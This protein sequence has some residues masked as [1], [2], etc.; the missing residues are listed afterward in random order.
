M[1]K[2]QVAGILDEIGTLLE[3]QGENP[4]RCLAYRN[5]ARAL[6]QLEENLADVIAADRLRSVPGIGE[7]LQDK[8]KT[9]V[10]TGALAFYEDLKQKTP[11]GLVQML[12]LSGMGPKKVRALY[13][14]LGIEDIEALKAACQAGRVAA[15]KGF[16]AKTQQKIL[17]GIDF[18]GQAGQRLRID[19]AQALAEALVEG[20]RNGPGII[21]MEVC[22][23]LRRWK[24]T[25]NDID[26]LV[27]SDD[28][29]P[30]MQRFVTLPGVTQIVAH[31]D[32]KSSVVFSHRL[33]EDGTQLSIPADLRVVRDEQFPFAMHYFTGSKEH[34][35][36]VRARAQQYGLKLNEYELAGPDR[37]VKCKDEAGVFRALDLAYIPPELRE[38]TG[39]IEA[40]AEARLPKL[41]ELADLRGTFHCH[42]TWSDGNASVEA[43]GLAAHALG[44]KYLGFGDHSQ[45]LTVANGL[46][47][48]RV[49]KQQAEID[50]VGARVKGIKLFKGSECDILADGSLD[51]D[52]EVLATF[53][54]VVAS[55]HSH[56]GQPEAEM[57]ARIIRAISHPRV[58]MLGHA[59]G[60]LLLRRDGYK[61]D[62]EAVLQ[63]AAK[64][65]TLIEINAHPQRLDLDWVHCKRAK[66]LGVCMVINPDAHSTA[67]L[68][69]VRYGVA[70]ARRAWLEKDHVF[71]TRTA[72]QVS[73][74][75]AAR[76]NS[77][78]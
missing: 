14:Q 74:A 28:A 38:H 66:A 16:G 4:F 76:K 43:M 23:S 55:V 25:I 5:A 10:T 36:A 67:D 64:H 1:D 17:E 32:T 70:V 48:D 33:H 7:T 29:G 63:A 50:A 58:T 2:H 21:R 65:G 9:L 68:A 78:H 11:P 39:E 49:R 60:R 3:L 41:I 24:E 52:D 61:V 46:T 71:N 53:D 15:L 35:I 51:Y 26:I 31:G 30:I 75:L 13:E 19:Q 34:N 54:Y 8:I 18:L 45:S 72:A 6:E 20:L 37:R 77:K 42:T 59:T 57:T 56:F 22:G 44:F 27:S 47:P 69:L 12:R 62:I 40:A 73:K